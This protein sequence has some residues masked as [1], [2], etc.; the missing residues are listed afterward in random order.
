MSS[1]NNE[2]AASS[3]PPEQTPL[4]IRSTRADDGGKHLH[5][6]PEPPSVRAS[7]AIPE[8]LERLVLDCLKKNP[9]DR[10]QSARALLERLSAIQREPWTHEE[11]EGWWQRHHGKLDAFSVVQ[12]ETPAASRTIQVDVGLRVG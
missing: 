5:V 9:G 12:G 7:R 6:A 1:A 2:H 4:R 8:P 3:S 11:A 10:P